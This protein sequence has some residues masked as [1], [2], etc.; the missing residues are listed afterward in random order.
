M[1]SISSIPTGW[2]QGYWAWVICSPFIEKTE[3]AIDEKQARQLEEKIMKNDL[4]FDDFHNAASKHKENRVHGQDHVD[5]SY[6]Q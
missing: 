6:T 1:I 2:L 4:N 5:A 3:K